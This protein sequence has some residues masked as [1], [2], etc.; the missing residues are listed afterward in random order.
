MRLTRFPIRVHHFCAVN[1]AGL[2]PYDDKLFGSINSHACRGEA[3]FGRLRGHL[4]KISEKLLAEWFLVF[5]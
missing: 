5:Y 1:F 2:I 3:R 4:F